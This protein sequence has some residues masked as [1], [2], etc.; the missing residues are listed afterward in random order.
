MNGNLA[1]DTNTAI[2]ALNGEVAVV[3]KLQDVIQAFLP[4]PVVGELLFGALNSRHAETNLSRVQQLIKRSTVLEMH[5]ETASL[6]AKI[7]IALKQKGRPIPENDIWIAAT[8]LEHHIPLIT[9]DA[10][11][12]WIED[13]VIVMIS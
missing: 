8:C 10:H 6:Y 4:L 2:A 1:L 13:L 12:K 5:L 7:R 3:N 9:S 11:F